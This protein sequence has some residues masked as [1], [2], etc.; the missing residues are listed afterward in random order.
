MK[1]VHAIAALALAALSNAG[2]LV[3]SAAADDGCDLRI[4]DLGNL[5]WEG[6]RG[7]GYDVYDPALYRE[8]V[9]FEIRA[10][11][12][13]LFAVGVTAKSGTTERSLRS[14]SGLRYQL[15]T[16]YSLA[17]PLQDVPGAAPN[18]LLL[19][20]IGSDRRRHLRFY[21][22]IPPLQVAAPGTYRDEIEVRL[23]EIRLGPLKLADTRKRTVEARVPTAVDLTFGGG[24]DG[25]GT[26]T[27]LDF[28]T[29]QR[30][31]TR[32][33]YFRARSNAGY[34]L[35]IASQNGGVMR[36]VEPGESSVLPYTLTIDGA[37]VGLAGGKAAELP[38]P[39]DPT[40][41]S[42]ITHRLVVRIEDF[43]DAVAGD[44][45]DVLTLTVEAR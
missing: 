20:I 7:A 4:D 16:D 42:G 30:F 15:Y 1:L 9:E 34:R 6:G 13:C 10:D 19:G 11:G 25:G 35:R 17:T 12:L 29:V 26:G 43:R 14:G 39:A 45:R 31:D 28:G 2:P 41:P 36:Y 44:Y 18:E 27:S 8:T 24:F 21:F 33:L 23:Y 22:S 40:A 32:D 37:A 5:Q 3:S 38:G